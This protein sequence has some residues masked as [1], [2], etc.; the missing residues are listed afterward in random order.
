MVVPRSSQLVASD[1]EYEL[2]AVT[3]FKKHGHEF[4]LKCREHKWTPRDFKFVEGGG[5][6]EQREID[7]V[8]GDVK[9][10]WGETVRLARTGWGEAVMVWIHILVLRVFVETVLRYG[11]PLDFVSALIKVRYNRPL[12][13][14]FGC[15]QGE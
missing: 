2:Y 13:F 5:E 10:L 8:G 9:R 6:Q 14:S 12:P 3:A 15:W 4:V 7:Q 1:S 11:L